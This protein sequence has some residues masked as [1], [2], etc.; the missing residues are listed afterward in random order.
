MKKLD[1]ER[2]LGSVMKTCYDLEVINW[3]AKHN[4]K[5]LIAISERIY[6]NQIRNITASVI[7]DEKKII[8]LAGP[9]SAGKTTSSRLIKTELSRHGYTGHT[10]SLDDFFLDR[11]KTPLLPSGYPDFENVTAIDLEYLAK[12]IDDLSR[13]GHGRLPQYEFKSGSRAGYED[14]TVGENDVVIFEGTHALNP[15]LKPGHDDILYKVYVTPNANFEIGRYVVLQARRLR[16]MRRIYRDLQTRGRSVEATIDG[17]NEVV[18]G[19]DLY[20]KPYKIYADYLLDTAHMYEPLL[21]DKYL[22]P[23]LKPL[24]GKKYVDEMLDLFGKI[25][26]I[27]KSAVPDNS[28]LWEF[29]V[30]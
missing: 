15:D 2:N 22:T 10:V 29:L 20:I 14:M 5:E 4:Q 13:K 16:L 25:G 6:H 18:R 8:L 30:K 19:E 17:W 12:F 3:N 23:L 7:T 26:K 28:L 27:D 21:W 9:S 11:D 24:K 1:I